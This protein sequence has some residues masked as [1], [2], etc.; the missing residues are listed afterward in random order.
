M[1][2]SEAYKKYLKCQIIFLH[3]KYHF[4]IFGTLK[5]I[6]TLKFYDWVTQ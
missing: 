4:Q 6:F 2:N 3:V 5:E 1:G